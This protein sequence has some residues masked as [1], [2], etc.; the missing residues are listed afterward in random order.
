MKFL[1]K[2]NPNEESKIYATGTIFTVVALFVLTG[3]VFLSLIA[4]RLDIVM[5]QPAD[6]TYTYFIMIMD[7]LLGLLTLLVIIP[8]TLY[9]LFSKNKQ[10]IDKTIT[11]IASIIVLTFIVGFF[12][13]QHYYFKKYSNGE[14]QYSKLFC[15][16]TFETKMFDKVI[17]K[18]G[19]F[20][21]KM[22]QPRPKKH[23]K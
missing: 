22:C 8:L 16:Q 7:R 23:G 14:L 15:K 2:L 12:S 17:E 3:V 21:P 9:Q 18:Q 11:L 13:G 5:S 10:E 20:P 6:E 19:K 4:N 1:E